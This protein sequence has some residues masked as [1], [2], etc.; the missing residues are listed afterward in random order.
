MKP[1]GGGILKKSEDDNKAA[2]KNTRRSE[3]QSVA[4][5]VISLD[6]DFYTQENNVKALQDY[7][8]I[9]EEEITKIKIIA[10]G[11]LLSNGIF[12]KV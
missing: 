10:M 5:Q 8:W 11:K 2:N 7:N 3:M 4:G 12:E 6:M 1:P 9:N